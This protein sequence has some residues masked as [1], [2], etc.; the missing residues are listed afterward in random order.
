[1]SSDSA[2]IT[3]ESWTQELP[4][5]ACFPRRAPLDIDVGCG[6]G[7]FLLARS[8]ANPARNFLGIDRRLQRLRKVDKK[9][10]HNNVDNIRLLRIEAAYAAGFLFPPL[11]VDTFTVFFPDPWPKRRHYQRRLFSSSFLD[12]L[13]RTLKPGG[14]LHVATDHL[15]YF[16]A[17]QALFRDDSRFVETDSFVPSDAERTEF[18]RLFTAQKADIGRASFRKTDPTPASPDAAPEPHS[19]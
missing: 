7:R 19:Q 4:W 15:P 14:L 17:I 8:Q 1:M 9:I 10:Q 6:K 13:I 18:E 11:S 3:P 12:A 5:D 2:I 16:E